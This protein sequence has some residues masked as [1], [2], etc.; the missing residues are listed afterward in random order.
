MSQYG[1]FNS[2]FTRR[3]KNDKTVHKMARPRY[4]RTDKFL[5]KAVVIHPD[6]Y[7]R[8]EGSNCIV[9]VKLFYT[10]KLRVLLSS[11][12]RDREHGL[13]RTVCGIIPEIHPTL[14]IRGKP[15]LEIV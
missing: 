11:D 9:S 3:N 2:H 14:D 7:T 8:G 13:H 1:N 12:K 15:R 5:G 4:A 6:S 10:A